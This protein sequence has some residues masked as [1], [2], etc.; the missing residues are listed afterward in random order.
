M[1]AMSTTYQYYR[2]ILRDQR[3]PC[4]FVDQDLLDQNIADI[5]D[6]AGTKTIR[7]ASKSLRSVWALK[8]ILS[9]SQQ[10][11]GI[12]SYN[13][14]EA[15]FLSRQGFDDILLGYPIWR[16]ADVEAVCAELSKG[17]SITLMI[18]LPEHVRHLD[19]LAKTMRVT[20]PVCIDVDMSSQFPGLYF[21]V[22]RSKVQSVTDSA[23]LLNALQAAP[24][25]RLRA[26]MGYEAAIAGMPDTHPANGI[27]NMM[28]PF[29]KRKSIAQIAVRR[30][31]MVE[32]IRARGFGL[33]IV[34]G[35]GTGS[36]ESTCAE[37]VVTEVTVGSGFFS[38]TL[39]DHY[40]AFKHQPASGFAIE[41][42]RRPKS[43]T[44]TCAGGGYVAS[45]TAGMD[46]VPQPY[47]PSGAAL[48]TQEA[49]GEVQ[50]PII[51]RGPERLALGDP[52]LMRHSKAGEL[53]ERF[54]TLLI[55]SQGRIIDEV[56]T[57]RGQG[58]C[59]L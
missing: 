48:I 56:P 42:V 50:T 3:M 10:Y 27:K 22:R 4:A 33:E 55:I 2:D 35:G 34:N 20:I 25:L 26:L 11:Q 29:L 44:Y 36:M 37:D 46:K 54:N 38:P 16:S 7:I 18:D 51:Y 43:D 5:P 1:T 32:A 15:V 45:G 58:E 9:A 49:A 19:A 12:M 31:E 24:G 59:F 53:C 8:R 6:R 14:N 23:D 21:G 30:R 41:I 57:Y 17:K 13:G 39:F 40:T 28:I 52:V 47:L